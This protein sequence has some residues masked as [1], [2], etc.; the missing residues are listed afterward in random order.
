DTA[1]FAAGAVAGPLYFL[2]RRLFTW[3]ISWKLM[4]LGQ[5]PML[6]DVGTQIVG[7]RDS[8][9]F[10]RTW[11]GALGIFAFVG[12]IYPKL[13]ADFRDGLARIHALRE[14]EQAPDTV[15]IPVGEELVSS[16]GPADPSD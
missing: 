6:I 11:T 13:D 8:D 5:V 7:L 1:M 4:V 10:W 16:R 2:L 12:W 15:S 9:G 14:Q 3:K